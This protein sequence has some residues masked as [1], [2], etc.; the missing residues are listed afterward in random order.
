MS[1]FDGFTLP[2][3]DAVTGTV[4]L[5]L[6][7]AALLVALVVIFFFLALLRTGVVGTAATAA[8]VIAVI[9]GLW[10]AWMLIAQGSERERIAERARLD[11]RAAELNART[12]LAGSALGCLEGGSGEAVERACEKAVFASPEAVAAATAYVAARLQLLADGT[13]FVARRDASYA[14]TLLSWRRGLETDRFG[15]VAQVLASR[16][17]CTPER[18]ETLTL[19]PDPS[20]VRLNLKERTY[21]AMVER[22]AAAWS[23]PGLRTSAP[24]AG[25]GGPAAPPAAPVPNPNVN[26]PSAASIPPVSIMTPEP[27]TPGTAGSGPEPIQNPPT[28]PRRPARQ[29]GPPATPGGAPAARAGTPARAP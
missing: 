26:F 28:P 8:R 10:L 23:A 15:L 12:A 3:V 18:C 9:G 22:H 6:W 27:G 5:P 24:A 20:R 29:S 25:A 21:D 19:F 17:N 13:E 4:P 11:A 7:S 14:P 16:D 2:G 1:F